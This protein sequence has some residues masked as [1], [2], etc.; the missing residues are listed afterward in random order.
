M[1]FDILVL[2]TIYVDHFNTLFKVFSALMGMS[3][4][5]MYATGLLWCESYITITNKIG[6]AFSISGVSLQNV[7]QAMI[8]QYSFL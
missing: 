6:S 2:F 7:M 5:S 1:Y 8:G 3:F 4:S